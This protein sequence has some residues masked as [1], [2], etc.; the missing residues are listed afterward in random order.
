MENLP[1]VS[2][3][4]TLK[5]HVNK[6]D[7]KISD[8]T[9]YI[10]ADMVL[11]GLEIKDF[12]MNYCDKKERTYLLNLENYIKETTEHFNNLCKIMNLLLGDLSK[13]TLTYLSAERTFNVRF[14]FVF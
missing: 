3:D 14:L 6:S 4:S 11:N 7:Y 8:T 2:E 10:E 9:F 1:Y 5:F 12:L 13:Y